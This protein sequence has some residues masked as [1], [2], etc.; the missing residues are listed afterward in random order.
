MEKGFPD[1]PDLLEGRALLALI[2]GDTERIRQ[3][4]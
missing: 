4:F 1:N 2:E 3:I